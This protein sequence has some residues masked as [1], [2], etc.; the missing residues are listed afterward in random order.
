GVL[1][2]VT[3]TKISLGSGHACALSSTGDVYCWG[4]NSYGEIGDATTTGRPSPVLVSGGLTFTDLGV[5]GY[6]SCGVSSGRA[7]CWGYNGTGEV[8]DA[9]TTNRLVPTAVDTSGVLSGLTIVGV[10]HG[11]GHGC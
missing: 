3:L 11:Q 4:K 10:A 2:G 5:G 8:G 9:T 6:D 7:Y 1:A